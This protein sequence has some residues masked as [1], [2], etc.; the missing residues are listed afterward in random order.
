M[1]VLVPILDDYE[2]GEYVVSCPLTEKEFIKEKERI[3]NNILL[4]NIDRKKGN[5]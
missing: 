5:L 1:Q 4:E 2:N 3:P